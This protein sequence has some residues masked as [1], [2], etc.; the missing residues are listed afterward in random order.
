[1]I[2]SISFTLCTSQYKSRLSLI[3]LFDYDQRDL[4]EGL[5]SNPFHANVHTDFCHFLFLFSFSKDINLDSI[6][7]D[8]L[9]FSTFPVL[10]FRHSYLFRHAVPIRSTA[11]F[12]LWLASIIVKKNKA[13]HF[14]YIP[15]KDFSH[16]WSMRNK[17]TVHQEKTIQK[18]V[19][20]LKSFTLYA[21][22][23]KR[24]G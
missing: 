7:Y 1:M 18:I 2:L 11:L 16:T 15:Q 13:S 17:Y 24:F 22:S 5:D 9:R 12:K 8:I 4:K 23:V 20:K 14:R 19:E 10:Q 3:N 6:Y 21:L